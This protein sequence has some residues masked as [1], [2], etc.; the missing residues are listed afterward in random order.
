MAR[1]REA[2]GWTELEGGLMRSPPGRMVFCKI[3]D[4]FENRKDPDKKPEY[5]CNLIFPPETDHS[6]LEDAVDAAAV[7]M[8]GKRFAER[9]RYNNPLKEAEV[10]LEKNLGVFGGDDALDGWLHL[11]AASQYPPDIVDAEVEDV[12]DAREA[13]AG[14]WACV[15]V[16]IKAWDNS[17]S[18]GVKAYLQN[19]QLLDDDDELNLGGR[20][21]VREQFEPAT[22]GDRRARAT[23]A[24]DE[25]LDRD[26]RKRRQDDDERPAREERRSRRDDPPEPR[27][28]RRDDDRPEPREERRSR[29]DDD[30]P[31]REERRRRDDDDNVVPLNRGRDR[32]SRD[33]DDRPRPRRPAPRRRDDD[34][35]E[36]AERVFD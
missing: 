13:Y 11:P 27:R 36:N 18:K 25:R 26:S 19:V 5:I 17:G 3:F 31:A 29:R 4:P 35:E 24:T 22:A 7:K 6:V 8:F 34:D 33:D 1:K 2:P 10:V 21:S 32:R 28:S 14:R 16:N 20:V 15:T 30:R 9:G 12:D 23:R